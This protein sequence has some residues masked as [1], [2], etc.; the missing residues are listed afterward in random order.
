[1]EKAIPGADHSGVSNQLFAAY[2][3][4]QDA[5]ALAS[6]IGEEELSPADRQYMAFGRLFEEHFLAQGFYEDRS[7]DQT[8]DLGWRLLSV[9]PKSELDRVDNQLIEAHYVEN[10]RQSFGLSGQA[11]EEAPGLGGE[12]R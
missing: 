5:R 2:A 10:A 1:M 12:G 4:V 9:L 8:L 6:V 11:S 3:K 7:I